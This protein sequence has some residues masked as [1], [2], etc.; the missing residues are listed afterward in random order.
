MHNYVHFNLSVFFYIHHQLADIWVLFQNKYIVLLIIHIASV[1][2]HMTYWL[3]IALD[4]LQ[5]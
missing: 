2:C 5:L 4:E 1:Y 3:E